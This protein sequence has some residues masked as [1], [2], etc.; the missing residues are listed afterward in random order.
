MTNEE[1]NL[2]AVLTELAYG[3]ESE[4]PLEATLDR[5][6]TP[7]F[8]QRVNGQVFQRSE[9]A[10]HVR[11]WRQAVVSGEIRVLEQVVMAT[12]TAGRYLF[13]TVSADGQVRTFESHLFARIDDG[14]VGRLIEV[15]R[16]TGD[17]DN[18]DFLE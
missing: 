18:D 17:D 7:D 14:K 13:R 11:E 5:L 12:R 10:A 2:A 4:E 15:A 16:Q 6:V 9:Y 1:F 3:N 8:V